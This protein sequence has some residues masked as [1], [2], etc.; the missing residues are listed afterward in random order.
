MNQNP[1]IVV[2]GAYGSGKSEYSI[3]LAKMLKKDKIIN[4]NT[5]I[6]KSEKVSLVD[7][8]VVNPYFRSRDVREI[9]EKE[10]IEIIAPESKYNKIDL[11]MISPQV[12]GAIND[13]SKTVIIDVGGDPTGC[14]ALGQFED[15]IKKRPYQM[16]LVVNT[17]R[18]FTSDFDEIISMKSMLE[19]ISKLKITEI[20][21]NTNLMEFTDIDTI[22]KGIKTIKEV[23][24]KENILFQTYLVMNDF[25]NKYPDEIDGV[26]KI[27]LDYFLPKPWE[28]VQ[29][30]SSEKKERFEYE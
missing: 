23:S 13:L 27:N 2:I 20:I 16:I 7:L 19:G 28:K 9:F 8:D 4:N 17:K 15:D 21:S 1:L 22:T 5:F 26:S 11:P 6:S 10:G 24:V 30:F 25:E 14:R 12:K 29:R 18:P 3:N